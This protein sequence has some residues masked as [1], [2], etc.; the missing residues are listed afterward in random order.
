MLARSNRST[1]SGEGLKLIDRTALVVGCSP[2]INSGIALELAKEGAKLVCV[3]IDGELAE[4]C[5]KAVRDLGGDAI[6]IVADATNEEQVRAA[7]DKAVATYGAIDILVNGAIVQIRLGIL[8]MAVA[9]FR[10]VIDVSLAGAFLF[11]Q[12]VAKSMIAQ[13][14]PGSIISIVSTEGH[15][16]NPNNIAYGTAKSGLLNFTRG[17]AME[18]A[19]YGI[20]VNSLSPTATDPREGDERAAAWGVKWKAPQSGHRPGYTVGAQGVPLGK[21]PA[22]SHYGR[23]AVFLASD[24]AEMITGFDM[25]V[26]GGTIA[27]YWRWNPG[28]AELRP[29]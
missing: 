28:I 12:Y 4:A 16:G 10:K 18:L 25:R 15:Q 9:Q 19:P 11:T 27:R 20:R 21:R 22:P 17:V 8:D 23:A 26:D 13:Q 7:V 29:V 5:A 3:D 6:A 1:G 2:S 24:D 14:R